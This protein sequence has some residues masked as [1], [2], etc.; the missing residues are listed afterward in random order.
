MKPGSLY[1]VVSKHHYY[2][3]KIWYELEKGRL[4][5]L[6]CYINSNDIFMVIERVKSEELKDDYIVYKVLYE[7]KV[8]FIHIKKH[9]DSKLDLTSRVEDVYEH[10]PKYSNR[11]DLEMILK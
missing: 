2:L 11:I 5:S 7:N 3:Y 4:L 8:G 6:L 9:K 1:K 10:G